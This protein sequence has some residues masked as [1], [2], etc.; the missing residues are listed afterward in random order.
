MRQIPLLRS[1]VLIACQATG[2]AEA[3]N[4]TTSS[5]TETDTTSTTTLAFDPLVGAEG[6]LLQNPGAESA[7]GD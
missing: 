5:D 2:S 7:F 6:D 1:I 4:T 3:A